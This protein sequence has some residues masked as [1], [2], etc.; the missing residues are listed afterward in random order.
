MSNVSTLSRENGVLVKV[1]WQNTSGER[2]CEQVEGE[3][4]R[5]ERFG[6]EV[7]SLLPTRLSKTRKRKTNN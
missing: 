7:L 6:G 2:S 1:N 5:G 3:E 4:G